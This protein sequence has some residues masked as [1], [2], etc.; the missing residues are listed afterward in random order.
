MNKNTTPIMSSFQFRHRDNPL[1]RMRFGLLSTLLLLSFGPVGAQNNQRKLAEQYLSQAESY[2]RTSRYE[3]AAQT[4]K[5]A[6]SIEASDQ[7]YRGLSE[8]CR[9]LKRYDQALVTA[10]EAVRLAPGKPINYETLGGIYTTLGDYSQALQAY[11]KWQDL[12][13]EDPDP[14]INVGNC[15]RQLGDYDLAVESFKKAISVKPDYWL[16]Y[17]YLGFLYGIDHLCDLPKAIEYTEQA[18]KL[19][20]DYAGNY[21][22][23]SWYYIFAGEPVKAVEAALSA[24]KE[25][26]SNHMGYTN[27][28]QA[29]NDLGI[30]TKTSQQFRN[31]ITACN[32][33]LALKK[34]DGETLFYLGLAYLN[35][36]DRS[37][38]EH[39]KNAV[40]GL[41]SPEGAG[42]WFLLGWAYLYLNDTRHAIEALER[43]RRL[44]PNFLHARSQ[45]ARGYQDLG[46]ELHDS[47]ELSKAIQILEQA[48][49]LSPLEGEIQ[50]GLS[51]YYSFANQPEK[52]IEA[53]KKA[54]QLS[55]DDHMGF[56]NLCRAYNDL[57]NKTKDAGQYRN[58]IDACN[59]ALTMK[60]D[61]G[62]TLL[63]LGQSYM[64]LNNQSGL[65]LIRKALAGLREPRTIDQWYLLG[66][67]QLEVDDI[68][69][70][71]GSF[72]EAIKLRPKFVQARYNLGI[73][74][75]NRNPM[76]NNR[77][78]I[79]AAR[80]Q[81]LE[82]I[83]LDPG[84]AVRLSNAINSVK[85]R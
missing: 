17:Y 43:S 4:Y 23:L 41:S 73:A 39:I 57:G 47:G 29:Y 36:Q 71:I 3:E 63:Y 18:A 66:V 26:P 59:R 40:R 55:P 48:A 62:E 15:Y 37:G 75:L 2:L 78:D 50:I 49:K 60:K 31:A 14:Y 10:T 67:A 72:R 35:L 13:P 61:D 1:A 24:V 77:V 42:A 52:A 7:A 56:T 58:A 82:L 34:D 53:G 16:G 22:N 74:Y 80:E 25:A 54:T 11:R 68:A 79:D 8:A 21:I 44:S 5:M 83:T 38:F 9:S 6:I 19:K 30:K 70:A 69:S 33:A 64:G 27:L 12:D 81:Y 28:C 46:S 51:W 32:Q 76:N 45:L 84:T 85:G 20:P 65:N